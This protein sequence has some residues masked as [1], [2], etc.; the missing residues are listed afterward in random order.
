MYYS[1]HDQILEISHGMAT[2][3]WGVVQDSGT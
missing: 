2:V 3:E 1:H